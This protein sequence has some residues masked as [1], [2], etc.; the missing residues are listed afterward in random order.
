MLLE[1]EAVL[2]VAMY[3]AELVRLGADIEWDVAG[4]GELRDLV[5]AQ[6]GDD[7][8]ALHDHL[9]SDHDLGSITAELHGVS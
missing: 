5:C 9:G 4:A 1:A 7:A 2:T 3:P 8:A 6:T